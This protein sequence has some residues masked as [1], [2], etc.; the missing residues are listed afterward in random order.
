MS[1]GQGRLPGKARFKLSFD[2][3]TKPL[4]KCLER[5]VYI[6]NISSFTTWLTAG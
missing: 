1:V 6:K 5:R 3:L 2:I 4:G